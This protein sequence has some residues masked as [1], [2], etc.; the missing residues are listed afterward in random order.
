MTSFLDIE[1]SN[2]KMVLLSCLFAI[3]NKYLQYDIQKSSLKRRNHIHIGTSCIILA[4]L[5]YSC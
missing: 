4:E 2:I 1:L 5:L 3:L